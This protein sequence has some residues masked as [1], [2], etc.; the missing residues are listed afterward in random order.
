MSAGT[1]KGV[2]A[3]VYRLIYKADLHRHSAF[4]HQESTRLASNED[5]RGNFKAAYAPTVKEAVEKLREQVY[6]W[7]RC[8]EESWQDVKLDSFRFSVLFEEVSEDGLFW[9]S[10]TST[11]GVEYSVVPV[12]EP[13]TV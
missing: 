6:E 11:Y 9:I 2:V 5:W 13:A 4:I 3:V 7:L 10:P 12:T 1:A 8:R